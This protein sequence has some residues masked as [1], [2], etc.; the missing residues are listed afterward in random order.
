MKKIFFLSCFVLFLS[1]FVAADIR[2]DLV[3]VWHSLP[4]LPAGWAE[5]YLFYK[6]GTYRYDYSQMDGAKRVISKWGTF[7]AKTSKLILHENK[8]LVVR[9]GTVADDGT[10][11]NI[12]VGGKEEYIQV[13]P[14][15]KMVYFFSQVKKE[16]KKEEPSL[17]IKIGKIK[18]W[19][20]SNDPTEK[21]FLENN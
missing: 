4:M 1:A 6:D 17:S 9:G 14:S 8:K 16:K 2:K 15:K 13:I 12:I 10:G 21:S 11:N 19:K 5:K 20:F 7:E 18:Y 3:G